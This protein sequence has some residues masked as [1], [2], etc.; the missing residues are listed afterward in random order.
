VVIAIIA[1]LIGLLLPAVQ[2]ARESATRTKCQNNLKQLGLALHSYHDSRSKFPLAIANGQTLF[3]QSATAF[4]AILPFIEQANVQASGAALSGFIFGKYGN[5]WAGYLMPGDYTDTN[6][7]VWPSS[8]YTAVYYPP[9]TDPFG[10]AGGILVWTTDFSDYVQKVSPANVPS[11]GSAIVVKLYLCPSDH[12]TAE[13]AGIPA[14]PRRTATL[15]SLSSLISGGTGPT[16]STTNGT[17][18]LTNYVA[19]PLALPVTGA[20]LEASFSDGT[21]NTILLVERYRMC[22]SMPAM[23]GYGYF[24]T[25]SRTEVY[26]PVFDVGVP[27]QVAPTDLQCIPGNPQTPHVGGM[28]VAF[29]DGSI[30][31]L[32]P[33]V[34]IA[35]SSTGSSVF[36]ALQT[37]QGGE[38]FTLE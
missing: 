21:S 15:V 1:I 36:S 23:W 11:D 25:N 4:G 19:N 34:N 8:K 16:D 30:R 37:P 10:A 5:G 24:R 18:A 22:N 9:G 35:T 12:T 6:G 28:P 17:L 33:N 26:G 32:N 7:T 3:G 20:R 27:F 13:A 29:A 38:V 2:K 14:P 31:V